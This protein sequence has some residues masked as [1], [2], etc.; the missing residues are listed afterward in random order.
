[1]AWSLALGCM[2][3]CVWGGEPLG[4]DVEASLTVTGELVA[5]TGPDA[6][7]VRRPADMA[8]RFEFQERGVGAEDPAGPAVERHY[9]RAEATMRFGD[10]TVKG[11]L[12]P[13]ARDVLVA[14]RGTTPVPYLAEGF[15]T[16]EE[17][18]LLDVPFD[19]L[20]IDDVLPGRRVTRGEAWTIPPDVAAGL[21]AIDTVES[22]GLEARLVDV[23]DGAAQVALSGIVDGAADG[24]PTHVTVEATL[25]VPLAER[26]VPQAPDGKP[27]DEGSADDGAS[28]TA[29]ESPASADAVADG[30]EASSD[31]SA[32]E[33]YDL[34][35][36]V[37][38]ANAVIIER[39]Q[40]S[41]VAPGFDV[42]ARVAVSRRPLAGGS[43]AAVAAPRSDAPPR[44]GKGMPG[45]VWHRDPAGRFE[46]VRDARWRK[47][48]DGESGLVMRL[49]DHGALVGQCS[50][51]ALPI[52]EGAT[53]PTRAEV[54][55]DWSRSLAGQVG[56]IDDAE[57]FTRGDGVRIVRI[58]S[59]GTAGRLPFR[60]MH[61]VLAAPG[62]RR[63]S[64]TFMLE[65]ASAQRFAAA[66]R[67]LVDGLAFPQATAGRGQAGTASLPPAGGTRPR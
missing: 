15:L 43:D 20:L 31:P 28:R 3:A 40:A 1:M 4:L 23:A 22:G 54:E 67:S 29:A 49:V 26:S 24:V 2:A 51:T 12:A 44:P 60:W 10:A 30:V 59:S 11:E 55:R 62:G 37:T 16:D 41:H 42:E 25:R 47:V 65:D 52:V 5:V 13:C 48:E 61:Y 19:S 27:V 46:L 9:R 21:L 66:D 33:S 53:P 39:R 32:A 36:P 50:I 64:V 17:Y 8:A 58:V 35:G 7:T 14:R 18:D 56:R 57:E 6:A 34:R 45:M 63:A 38:D